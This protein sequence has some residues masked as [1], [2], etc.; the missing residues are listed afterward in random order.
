[1]KITGVTPWLI[2]AP[3]PYLDTADE[4]PGRERQY[5]FG[6]VSTDEDITGWGEGA[7]P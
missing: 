1:M 5:V 7:V 4:A 6:Q 2:N 3:R